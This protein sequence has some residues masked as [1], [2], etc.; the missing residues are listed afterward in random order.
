MILV[1]IGMMEEQTRLGAGE[2]GYPYACG[3]RGVEGGYVGDLSSIRRDVGIEGILKNQSSG[4]GGEVET[5]EGY[6]DAGRFV[7]L[8]DRGELGV[9]EAGGV[10][11]PGRGSQLHA[12]ATV[13]QDQL[14]LGAI[15]IDDHD[16]GWGEGTENVVGVEF[17]WQRSDVGDSLSVGGP[18][19]IVDECAGSDRGDASRLA[20]QSVGNPK[21]VLPDECE[22]A[23]RLGR[24]RLACRKERREQERYEQPGQRQRMQF[25]FRQ[26]CRAPWCRSS[27]VGDGR[28]RQNGCRGEWVHCL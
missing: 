27:S 24:S 28:R 5:A 10:G 1:E 11:Q 23:S 6:L 26:L 15:G 9:E 21:V 16:V 2:F 13:S 3:V 7:V 4:Q 22:P 19:R 17:G 20:A 25:A 14:G 12:R 18:A 8:D